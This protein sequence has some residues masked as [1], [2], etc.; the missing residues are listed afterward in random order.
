MVG[1]DVSESHSYT[2]ISSNNQNIPQSKIEPH[3][4]VSLNPDQVDLDQFILSLP[5]S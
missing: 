4:N 1:G 5:R 2:K 3:K